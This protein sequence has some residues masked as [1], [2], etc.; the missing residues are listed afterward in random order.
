VADVDLGTRA[1]ARHARRSPAVPSAGRTYGSDG[2]APRVIDLRTPAEVEASQRRLVRRRGLFAILLLAILQFGDVVTTD[3]LAGHAE[4]MNPVADYFL[5]RGT[6]LPVKLA[7]I[8]VLAAVLAW[9]WR[10]IRP[11]FVTWLWVAVG[12]YGIVVISNLVQVVLVGEL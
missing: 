9:G 2:R 12:I 3:A 7:I 4:E 8:G 5:Q 1:P 6:L 10:Q 11:R